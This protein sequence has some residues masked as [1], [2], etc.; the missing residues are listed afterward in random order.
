MILGRVMYPI[1]GPYSCGIDLV[2]VIIGVIM[3]ISIAAI[4]FN[5]NA[6][7]CISFGVKDSYLQCHYSHRYGVQMLTNAEKGGLGWAKC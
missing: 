7:M 3:V 2:R 6:L 4:S 1:L 5:G